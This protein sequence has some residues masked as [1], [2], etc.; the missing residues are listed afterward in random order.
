M[1]QKGPLFTAH[2]GSRAARYKAFRRDV[3]RCM[4]LLWRLA[5]RLIPLRV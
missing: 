5:Q 2:F 4:R 1:V 3:G